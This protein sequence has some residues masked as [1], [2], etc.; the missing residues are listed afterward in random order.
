MGALENTASEFLAQLYTLTKG[1]LAAQQSMN[2]VGAAVGLDKEQSGKVAEDLIGDGLVEIK[3]LSGGVGIT[4]EG[5]ETVQASGVPS[6][7]GAGL[8]LGSDRVIEAEGRSSV[9]HLLN[10]IKTQMAQTP[11]PYAQLEEMV[12]DIKTIETQ[13]LSPQPKVQVIKAVFGSL[14]QALSAAGLS[15]LATQVDKTIKA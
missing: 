4:A 13:M 1:D 6:Q 10:E 2:D 7:G 12:I 14:Q 9:T 5:I 8:S 15:D 11:T 3:T